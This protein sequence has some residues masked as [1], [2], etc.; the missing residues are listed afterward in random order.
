M[1]GR[2]YERALELQGFAR[3]THNAHPNVPVLATIVR[4]VTAWAA[5]MKQQLVEQLSSDCDTETTIKAVDSLRRLD[6]DSDELELRLRFLAARDTWM[7]LGAVAVPTSPLPRFLIG[8]A[9]RLRTDLFFVV[10]QY[11]TLFGAGG[12]Q[13]GTQALWWF[14]FR[15]IDEFVA[16]LESKAKLL[17]DGEDLAAVMDAALY[18]ASALSRVG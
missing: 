4:D 15:K 7:Q 1:P 17:T 6:G 16:L 13:G 12:D 10:T 9:E 14:A 2:H 5:I 8:R 18:T 11:H 3:R